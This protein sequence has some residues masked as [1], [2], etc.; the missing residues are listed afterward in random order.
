MQK[1]IRNAALTLLLA[2]FFIASSLGAS[3]GELAQCY[4]YDSNGY[5]FQCCKNSAWGTPL[6]VWNASCSSVGASDDSSCN[7]D[8]NKTGIIYNAAP[9]DTLCSQC[10]AAVKP[11][12]LQ[13]ICFNIAGV[14]SQCSTCPPP[15]TKV[16]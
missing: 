10:T 15:P 4:T 3:A 1:F 11:N 7:R 2:S 9:G 14:S 8:V 13:Q 16:P 12:Q 5:P 6:W